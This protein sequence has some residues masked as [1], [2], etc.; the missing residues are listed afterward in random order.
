M[1]KFKVVSAMVP[2]PGKEIG[3]VRFVV[4]ADSMPKLSGTFAM[5]QILTTPPQR[6]KLTA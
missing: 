2:E 4:F 5:D 6:H 3:D 1:F